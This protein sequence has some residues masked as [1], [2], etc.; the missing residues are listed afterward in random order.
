MHFF[1]RSLLYH[2]LNSGPQLV[3]TTLSSCG[4]GLRTAVQGSWGTKDLGLQNGIPLASRIQICQHLTSRLGLSWTHKS[5]PDRKFHLHR[6]AD[7]QI[8]DNQP[9]HRCGKI[10]GTNSRPRRVQEHPA[11]AFSCG[12]STRL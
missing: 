7:I 1:N 8:K 12:N 6:Q 10:A 2:H 9:S 5:Y 11:L 3:S 4:A